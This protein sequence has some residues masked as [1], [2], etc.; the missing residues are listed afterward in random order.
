LFRLSDGAAARAART[1]MARPPLLHLHCG[2][3]RRHCG[4]AR[5]ISFF[6]AHSHFV[7]P[8]CRNDLLLLD[9]TSPR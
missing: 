2:M 5:R 8:A 6:D 1:K 4:A 9:L 7:A 3:R